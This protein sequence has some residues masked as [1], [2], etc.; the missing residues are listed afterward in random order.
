MYNMQP[1][2]TKLI[3]ILVA[4]FLAISS[5][6][7]PA[8]VQAPRVGGDTTL[9]IAG[10]TYNLSGSGISSSATSIPLASLTLP[11]TGQTLVDSDFSSIFYVTLEP[12]NRTRQEIVSCTTVTASTLSGCV[13]GLSPITP[14]T[15][16]S[17]LQFAHA[18]GA[19][20]I[21]SNPPQLYNQFAAKDNDESITGVYNFSS[22][23]VPRYDL[24]PLNHNTGTI[25]ATTSEFASVKFVQQVSAAGCLDAAEGNQGCVELGTRAEIAST[26]SSGSDARLVVPASA[27]TSTPGADITV[28]GGQGET[29]VVVSEDDGKINQS[30]LDLTESYTYSG[31]NTFNTATSTFNAT[32]SI[33]ALANTAPLRLNGVNYGFPSAITASS[34]VLMPDTTGKLTWNVPDW[35]Q[36]GETI[37]G[38]ATPTTTI[39][40]FPARKDLRIIV[41]IPTLGT[42]CNPILDYNQDYTTKYNGT[43][44]L[45][46]DLTAASGGG[47]FT[48]TYL[49]AVT[50]GTTSAM[51]FTVDVLNET[52]L[53]KVSTI[54]GM[55][56]TTALP[57]PLT[58]VGMWTNTSAQITTVDLAC[59]GSGGTRRNLPTGTRM[60]I[61]GKKD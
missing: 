3:S 48:A 30:W 25:V 58:G 35:N 33:S 32:T 15:A 57:L 29:Y 39:S 60:T 5:L 46:Y 47:D 1:I 56:S 2:L 49:A 26:T 45:G 6:F 50:N 21:F 11:Q 23:S 9:P 16:S 10:T 53:N 36:L 51:Y 59:V 8:P 41:N 19:Q 24:V 17:T 54:S 44:Y 20:V 31:A 13:R 7:S 18:G 4:P 43:N 22:T 55:A 28:A 12:G 52:S 34:T 38:G 14:Y 61:Y 37:V 40:S 27:A 42:A